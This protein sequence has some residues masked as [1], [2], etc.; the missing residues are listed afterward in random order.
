VTAFI[1]TPNTAADPTR[2]YEVSAEAL[3][4]AHARGEIIGIFHSHP[5]GDT[6]PSARDEAQAQIGWLYVIGA[7]GALAAY[8]AR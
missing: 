7:R 5:N 1:E 4:A 6:R 2:A 8:V 3:L